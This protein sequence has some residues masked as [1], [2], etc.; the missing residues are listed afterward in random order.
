MTVGRDRDVVTVVRDP[1]KPLGKRFTA[2]PDGSVQKSA[3]VAMS[4]VTAVM[5]RVPDG[6]ALADLL[7]EVGEDSH[8]AI[9]PDL[10]KGVELGEEFVI[11]PERELE[12]RLDVRGRQNVIGVHLIEYDGK[13]QKVTGRLSE[14]ILTGAWKFLD[15][16]IDIHTP[17]NFARMGT[18]RWLSEVEKLLP[19][20]SSTG[21]VRSGSV[22]A[23]VSKDGVPV[24][25]G[26]GHFWFRIED[27]DDVERLRAAVMVRAVMS[28]LAWP[29]PRYSKTTGELR[30][31]A[32]AT[33]IDPSVFMRGRLVF[34]GK[35]VVARSLQLAKSDVEVLAPLAF[36]TLDSA[37]AELPGAERIR[38]L[39]RAAG[40]ELHIR[41]T[42]HG[43]KFDAYDLSLDTVLETETHGDVAL[44]S[45]I[46]QKEPLRCQ[47]PFR[48]SNSMAGKFNFGASGRP[49]VHD[50]GTNTNHWLCDDDWRP[51]SD[52]H[53]MSQF[54]VLPPLDNAEEV[55]AAICRARNLAKAR[56]EVALP[57]EEVNFNVVARQVEVNSVVVLERATSASNRMFPEP[58]PGPMFAAVEVALRCAPKP[59]P[60]LTT[61]A[62]LVGMAAGCPGAYRLPSGMRP[63]LYGVGVA[64]TGAGKD[65]PRQA[66][67]AIGESAGAIIIGKP[68][69]GQ[70]L[71]DALVSGRGMLCEVDEI[72]HT[73]AAV[74]SSKAPTHLVELSGNLLKLFTASG[75]IYR[76]RVL[77]KSKSN[78]GPRDLKHTC[79][80]LLGFATPQTLG[81]A[82][83]S[84]NV[85]DGLLGRVL[86]AWGDE[87][88]RPRRSRS[89]FDLPDSCKAAAEAIRH[90]VNAHE[91]SDPNACIDIGLS[92]ATE[93]RLDELLTRL[94]ERASGCSSPF[95]KALR[96][97][98][99]EKM[100][101]IAG[102]LAVWDFPSKPTIEARH[103]DWALRVIE[104]SDATAV[105]FTNEFMHE[106]E[107]QAEA[108][109]VIDVVRR[110]LRGELRPDRPSEL[111]VVARGY[112]PRS[113]VLRRSKL[114]KQD[115]DRAAVHLQA[116]EELVV[117]TAKAA[118][119][120]GERS[121][122]LYKLGEA[123]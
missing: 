121:I 51:I 81:S 103:V 57:T 116:T 46:D 59:Q 79:L 113:L 14:N 88:V 2:L 122:T 97:R 40:C 117:V 71:E 66:G 32:W 39:T 53:V 42:G 111:A 108:S 1:R 36:E 73:L 29:K 9:I 61:L 56:N 54:D 98:S 99:Y 114:S 15:R 82:V 25:A 77:A 68:G 47:A 38:E 37:R 5:R 48:E 3:G 19:G 118:S 72:A 85:A 18:D 104:A 123:Q 78:L 67:V 8:A 115:F 60:A 35:P 55:E 102:V 119:D 44:A 65:L 92:P 94:D 64:D 26:N 33:V 109:R 62:V 43:L 6:A 93:E 21:L 110:I 17:A 34:S 80:S 10:F 100:E 89:A 70:G 16:D 91:L 69:S 23:R 63:N 107:V 101:R 74:N 4:Y 13:S 84:A 90:S 7:L 112:A 28:G 41:K 20:V 49:F 83:S 12:R 95:E 50:V 106:G 75:S 11:L 96:V 30:G 58:F 86:F 31:Q 120:R 22:S 52:A 105:R 87:K 27:P 45:L 24:G 76:T